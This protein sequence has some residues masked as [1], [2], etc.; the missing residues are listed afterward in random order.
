MMSALKQDSQTGKVILA[1]NFNLLNWWD[2][3]NSLC[4]MYYQVLL[5][6]CKL[7]IW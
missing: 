5:I 4:M 3:M 6:H 1:L 2:S 7:L